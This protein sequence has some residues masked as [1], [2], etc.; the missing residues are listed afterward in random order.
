MKK[1]K[2]AGALILLIIFASA[3]FTGRCAAD[4]DNLLFEIRIPSE[5]G[6]Q[7]VALDKNGVT[8]ALGEV[9]AVPNTSRYPSYTASAWGNPGEVC[10]AAVNAIHLLVSV[11]NEKGRTISI[12]PQ[13]TIA[14]AAGTNAAF[15]L[16]SKAG[17]GV[18]GAWAPV[19]GT[20]AL[21]LASDGSLRRLAKD[22]ALPK[23][24]DVLILRVIERPMPYFVEIE[25][26]PG[27]RVTKWDDHGYEVIARV[28]RRV[29]GTGRFEGT[30]FQNGSRLRANHPGVIDFSTAGKGSV[31]GFQIIPLDHVLTSKE[32]Q[33]AWDMTQWMIV[34]PADC[35]SH[36]AGM[37]PLFGGAL[38]PGP[39]D[40]EEL[41]DV[42]STYGRRSLLLVRLNGGEWQFL[43]KI[44]GRND[45]GLQEVTHLRIYY[46][47]VDE[48]L[49]K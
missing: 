25:N 16:S 23:Q 3:F 1:K 45:N 32:M 8:H 21:V 28:I 12:L 42:W 20:E 40:G 13:E 9:L 22:N 26:R 14:P 10:A 41:W 4:G 34:A 7:A 35:S 17:E 43:P 27:G 5:I 38:I 36:L 47:M 48:P 24:G 33:S 29:S 11:E 39:A 30:L 31:G 19:S 37:F 15:V 2:N 49:K 18:F 46:P 44:S 6:A